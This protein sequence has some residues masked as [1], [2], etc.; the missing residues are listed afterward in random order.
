MIVRG[1]VLKYIYCSVAKLLYVMGTYIA[2]DSI[3]YT[4]YCFY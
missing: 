2:T 1:D 3:G 4:I